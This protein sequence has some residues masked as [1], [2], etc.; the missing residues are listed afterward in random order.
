MESTLSKKRQLHRD[1][2]SE[3]RR[4]LAESNKENED[5]NGPSSITAVRIDDEQDKKRRDKKQADR[6]RTQ[7]IILWVIM[8]SNA[9][10][11]AY[12]KRRNQRNGTNH[13]ISAVTQNT[14][15]KY[16]PFETPQVNL[17]FVY[18]YIKEKLNPH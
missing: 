3:K 15:H 11:W 6:Q 2:A 1:L 17:S 9:M 13:S 8:V 12:F 5:M 7:E 4:R 16:I 10:G 18:K 14:L